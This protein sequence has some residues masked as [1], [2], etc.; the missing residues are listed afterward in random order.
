M[1][2]IYQYLVCLG[3][4]VLSQILSRDLLVSISVTCNRMFSFYKVGAC[5][6]MSV[7]TYFGVLI[8]RVVRILRLCHRVLLY[9][10]IS[11]C[12]GA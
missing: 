9:S 6:R 8:S 2:D 5:Q 1:R 12:S 7:R 10:V 3:N 4:C 11:V